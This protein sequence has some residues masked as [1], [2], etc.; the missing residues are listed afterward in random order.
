MQRHKKLHFL[1]LFAYMWND[2]INTLEE[3]VM[4]RQ[5]VHFYCFL[6]N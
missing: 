5:L 3:W 6:R 1:L 4:G 2:G